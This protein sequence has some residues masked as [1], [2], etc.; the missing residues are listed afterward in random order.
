MNLLSN[1]ELFISLLLYAID[2]A[3]DIRWF[4]ANLSICSKRHSCSLVS[5]FG[6]LLLLC[7]STWL[8][9]NNEGYRETYLSIYPANFDHKFQILILFLLNLNF[10]RFLA[11]YS[12][13]QLK[14]CTRSKQATKV[15]R[16]N[17]LLVSHFHPVSPQC[18]H[19]LFLRSQS[20]NLLSSLHF[21]HYAMVQG[22]D[23]LTVTCAIC[24]MIFIPSVLIFIGDCSYGRVNE[25]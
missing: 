1:R 22:T 8:L 23:M 12:R 5:L 21:L 3:I 24:S 20:L 10:Y 17:R 15:L 18:S 11:V 7:C 2:I 16:T 6:H 19:I 9:K 4:D 25:V 13:L 14:I